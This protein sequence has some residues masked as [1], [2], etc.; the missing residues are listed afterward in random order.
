M[1]D[2]GDNTNPTPGVKDDKVEI[3]SLILNIEK[4]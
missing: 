2:P 1:V 3:Q 4:I